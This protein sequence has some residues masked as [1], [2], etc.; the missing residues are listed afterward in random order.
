MMMQ[1]E[2]VCYKLELY[3]WMWVKIL[4]VVFKARNP[5]EYSGKLW[6]EGVSYFKTM[7]FIDLW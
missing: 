4:G 7:H 1:K 3:S 5:L 6:C 2:I